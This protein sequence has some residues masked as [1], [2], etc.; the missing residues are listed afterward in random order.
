LDCSPLV[1]RN[2]KRK[3]NYAAEK[4]EQVAKKFRRSLELGE[5]VEQEEET[6]ITEDQGNKEK[7]LYFDEMISGL[8]LAYENGNREEQFRV[9]TSLPLS[10]GIR[11]I[12]KEFNI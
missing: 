10:W 8:K 5:P 4:T 12:M 7:T 3:R 11:K 6:E 1:P 9:L 2:L